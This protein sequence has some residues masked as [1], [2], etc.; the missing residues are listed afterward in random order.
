MEINEELSRELEEDIRRSNT[1]ISRRGQALL[2]EMGISNPQFN[3]LLALYEFG[4]LTMGDLGKHLFTACS[5]AT[6]LA[7]RLERFGLVERKRDAR[8]RRIVRMH[9]LAK[10]RKTVEVVMNERYRFLKEVLTEYTSEE[11]ETMLESLK[12]LIERVERIDKANP[13]ELENVKI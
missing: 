5:T 4:P 12:R 6:D 8:D 7:D 2:A 11:H 9:L 13:V 1:V 10:G 3:T